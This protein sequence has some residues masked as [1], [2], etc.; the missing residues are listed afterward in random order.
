MFMYA[1]VTCHA[2]ALRYKIT[3]VLHIIHDLGVYT[4]KLRVEVHLLNHYQYF[5]KLIAYCHGTYEEGKVM[6]NA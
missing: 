1:A 3:L 5:F 2:F 6:I 4:D